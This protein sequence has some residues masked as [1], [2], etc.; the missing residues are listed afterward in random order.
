MIF[1]KIVILKSRLTRALSSPTSP[2]VSDSVQVFIPLIFIVAIG[3]ADN[4]LVA[5]HYGPATLELALFN[6]SLVMIC[7]PSLLGLNVS[8]L[9]IIPEAEKTGG[10]NSVVSVF[11]KKNTLKIRSVSSG[12]RPYHWKKS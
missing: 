4:V 9:R 12:Y 10:K 6:S 2:A 3:L 5:R 11:Y 7:M 1:R 8:I